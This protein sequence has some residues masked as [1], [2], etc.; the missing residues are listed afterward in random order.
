MVPFGAMVTTKT[1]IRNPIL[2]VE[3]TGQCGQNVLTAVKK[4]SRQYIE[5]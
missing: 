2:E 5:N 4:L 1:L 3:H